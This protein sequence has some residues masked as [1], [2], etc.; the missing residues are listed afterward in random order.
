MT[1]KQKIRIRPYVF[2]DLPEMGPRLSIEVNGK[3]L[4]MAEAVE[5]IGEIVAT[6]R[7]AAIFCEIHGSLYKPPCETRHAANRGPESVKPGQLP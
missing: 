2:P 6:E 5:I 1:R 4:P 3:I 7:S